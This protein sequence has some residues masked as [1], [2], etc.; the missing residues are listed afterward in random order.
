MNGPKKVFY[1]SGKLQEETIYIN[2][3]RNGITKWYTDK[4]KLSIEYNY[5]LGSLEGPQKTYY[6]EDGA[7]NSVTI[8]KG[9]AMN[10]DYVEYFEDG[11]TIKI[12][13]PYLN[14]KKNG[15]WKTYDKTGKII[16]TQHYKNDVLQK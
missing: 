5:V 6:N 14:D 15:A 4:G 13:G 7:L 8:Y 2:D 3:K 9:N 10:G 12:V 16:S 1:Q 11:K